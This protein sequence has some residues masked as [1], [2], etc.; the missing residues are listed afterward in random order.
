MAVIGVLPVDYDN[1]GLLS[2]LSVWDETFE[3]AATA[4]PFV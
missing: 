3:S 4:Y 1:L 2:V